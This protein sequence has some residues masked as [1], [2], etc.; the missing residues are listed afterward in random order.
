[1]SDTSLYTVFDNIAAPIFVL[2]LDAQGEPVYS[3]LNAHGRALAER[4]LSDYLN[5]TAK[6]VYPGAYG[7]IAYARHCAAFEAG[8]LA[9]YDLDL[10]IGGRLRSIRTT[11]QPDKDAFGTVI[12]VFAL[13][14]D[15]TSERNAKDAKVEFDTLSS[16]MEQF[17]YHAAH[18]LRSPMRN[19]A[20]LTDLLRDSFQGEDDGK[21]ELI[22]LIDKVV[23]RSMELI[24]DVLSHAEMNSVTPDN[25]V[26]S[27]PALC[28]QIIELLDPQSQ[29]HFE[30]S[31][32]TVKAD[33]TAMMIVLRNLVDN[34]IKHGGKKTLDINIQVE[35]GLPGM[36]DVTLTD[37]GGGFS[38]DALKALNAGQLKAEKSYGLFGAKRL[39]S[40]RGGTL[41][42]HNHP[43]GTG[44][45]V[46]FSLP[47]GILEL[48]KG[49][50]LSRRPPSAA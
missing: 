25:T 32:K 50:T 42:A 39:I 44:A 7:R 15:V 24:A 43:G 49:Q 41:V 12:R 33:K 31:V 13:S 48:R 21:L 37:T 11:L 45:S 3:V 4:P 38:P 30:T 35:T 23:F 10:P 46:R 17:V 28:H 1:M 22:D 47:G 16:E 29:H 40:A 20:L 14:V 2:E 9:T 6:Q 19:I 8:Q 34:S 26:F 18:D 27:F 5:K 36:L